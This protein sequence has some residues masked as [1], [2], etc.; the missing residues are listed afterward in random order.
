MQNMEKYFGFKVRVAEFLEPEQYF[1]AKDKIFSI[2]ANDRTDLSQY[3]I[4]LHQLIIEAQHSKFGI[5]GGLA[6]RLSKI[7]LRF[8]IN[9]K[10]RR[11][12]DIK[13]MNYRFEEELHE[14][15]SHYYAPERIGYTIPVEF[16]SSGREY[17]Q[18][19]LITLVRMDLR[20]D[21]KK[22]TVHVSVEPTLE[23]MS[24]LNNKY[25]ANSETNLN[26]DFKKA[27]E[28]SKQI[29]LSFSEGA[30]KMSKNKPN[31]ATTG[32]TIINATNIG[33]V[34]INSPNST[35][36]GTA[37]SSNAVL[38]EHLV[39]DLK[40]LQ[41]SLERNPPGEMKPKEMGIIEG[42]IAEAPK[43]PDA[44]DRLKSVGGWMLKST[45]KVGL[46]LLADYLKGKI[47]L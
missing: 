22:I 42:V 15:I 13:F 38:V 45:E 46:S 10:Q 20:E 37:T 12:G 1:A 9:P 36:N 19:T 41:A 4:Y 34:A 6:G 17:F 3:K 39:H 47:S 32:Q 28:I 7:F 25:Q 16:F 24:K 27:T 29:A 2:L 44:L 14:E 30:P 43:N 26:I 40:A 8:T 18:N 11:N 21:R 31:E 33:A 35:A 5:G 23:L